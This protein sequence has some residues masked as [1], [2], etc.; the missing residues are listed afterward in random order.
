MEM[1]MKMKIF[2]SFF[3]N[4]RLIVPRMEERDDAQA[5]PAVEGPG[6]ESTT[7]TTNPS[8][9][10]PPSSAGAAEKGQL[11]I[12]TFVEEKYAPYLREYTVLIE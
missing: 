5:T 12:D 1:E 2:F 9:S 6:N 7:H 3:S 4:Q 8:S 10:T 11:K